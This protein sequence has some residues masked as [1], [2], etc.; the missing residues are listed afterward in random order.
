MTELVGGIGGA[1]SRRLLGAVLAGG[2]S[3]RFGTEKALFRLG[4]RP[5]ARYAMDALEPWTTQQVVITN[6]DGVSEALGVQG[7]PDDVPGLGPVGG[8]I[9]ALS[10][11]GELGLDG[12][13]LLACDLPLVSSDLVGN[14]IRNW[15]A[16]AL[17][18]APGSRGP[19]GFEPLCS[20]FS[21][22]GLPR[23]EELRKGRGGGGFS[24]KDAFARLEGVLIPED[25]VGASEDVR[26]SF[27][28]VNTREEASVAES[29]LRGRAG[30][31]SPTTSEPPVVCIIGK[32][33][34]GKTETTVALGSELNRRGYRVMSVKHGHGFQLDEPGRDSWR[35]RH[36]GGVIRTVLAGPA[37][38]GV[39][40]SWPGEEMGL[41]EIVQRFLWDADIV[42][43]EGFKSASQ[44][45]VEVFRG[46]LGAKTLHGQGDGR[47]EGIIAMVSD[48]ESPG[49][50]IPVFDST[51]EDWVLEL[52]DFLEERFLP[53]EEGI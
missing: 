43:A 34:S 5:M 21:V 23:L 18:V 49:L 51:R 53:R 12:V 42:L 6:E 2:M 32:K 11:A 22:A 44:P 40:G 28:N 14:I 36:E 46:G 7:R 33:N 17:A 27:S 37:D 38:F 8:L 29:V 52:A 10:W 16:E 26:L 4:G 39:I 15:P 3:R 30:G 9:T 24:M 31:T 45:K 50:P 47:P 19:L 13:F 35:H 25:R 20:A 48:Q 1:S 41:T